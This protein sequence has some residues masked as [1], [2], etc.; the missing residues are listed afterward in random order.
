MTKQVIFCIVALCLLGGASTLTLALIAPPAPLPADAPAAEFSAGRAMRDLK[1][2]AREPHPMGVN[3]ARAAV[4]DYLLGE[5][6][7]LGLAP[8]VQNTFGLRTFGSG[9]AIGGVVENLLVS[10]PGS[11]SE[12]AILLVAHYDST[13]G[14]PGAADNSAGVATVLELL[15]ALRAGPRLRQDVMILF[16]DGEEPGVIG[17]YAFVEQHPW[18]DDVTCVI[19][20][21]TITHA[22]P[23]ILRVSGRDG[24]WIQALGRSGVSRPAFVSLPYH[25]FPAGD[26]DLVPFEEAGIPGAYFAATGAT[27]EIHTSEDRPEIVSPATLQHIGEQLLALVRYLGNQTGLDFR[28]PGETFFPAFGRLVHYPAGWAA[29]L[30]V[31]AGLC[32]LGTLAYGFVKQ[33]LTWR[34]V[35]LGLLTFLIYLATSMGLTYLL[36]NGLQALHPEYAYS[37]VRPHLSEDALY[38]AGFVALSLAV[39]VCLIVLTRRKSAAHDLAAG[40]LII[41]LPGAVAA[42]I[43]V[44]ATSYLATWVLLVNSLALLLAFA[45]KS[46]RNAWLL[47]GLGFLISAIL[48]TFL[49]LPV[50]YL[51][52]LGSGFPMWWII[53][54]ASSIW[55]GALLPAL[56]W[57]TGPK[58]W[59]LPA[60]ALAVALGLLLAG[61]FLVGRDS[62]PPPANS[63]G[64]WLDADA[65][66][67]SWVA[68]I[69][70]SRTDARTTTQYE[71]AFP[72]EMDERQIGLLANPVRRPYT[73]LFP[74]APP[75]S[76][77]TSEAPKLV[78]DGPGLD[79]TSDEWLGDRRLM[80]VRFTTSMHDRLY[81]VVPE[82]LLLAI[83]V[84]NN[85]R[86]EFAGVRGVWLRLDGMPS[87]AIEIRFEF[88][89]SDPIRFLLV[90][91]KTGLPSFP[92]LVTQPEPGT[93]PSPGEF[94]QGV[95]TDFTA[96]TRSFELPASSAP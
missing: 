50:I 2:I 32:F 36:W 3:Q 62:P 96:V 75:F 65:R 92:G 42:A 40:A 88:A 9:S 18:I 14:G 43:L 11:S 26:T 61:H 95:A 73:E 30:A 47:S 76:V 66:E 41:W 83:T 69:G 38:V 67:A 51:A 54:G 27:T 52:Y 84:P 19:N 90:E 89:S 17:A 78:L 87:A 77:L 64:Y 10:L 31:L 79:V 23:S 21:D 7:A 20:L 28:A 45:A 68:F 57:I 82:V 33:D 60:A 5:I 1:I 56:D 93:M 53:V 86:T 35:G 85:E 6:R 25:L 59:P 34:G 49:W 81:I 70:G 13:P 74:E 16:A 39:A 4:R 37:A 94:L 48:V 44:P 91:E 22:P 24:A 71:V 55:L 29:P 72:T 8:Q 58:R 80:A 63:I 12:G 15:R 46:G